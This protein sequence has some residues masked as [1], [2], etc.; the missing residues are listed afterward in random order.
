MHPHARYLLAWIAALLV[1]C[2][3]AALLNYLIDPY[4]LFG[5]PRHAG[6]NEIK[7]AAAERVRVAKPYMAMRAMPKVVIGGNSRPEMGLDP[8]SACWDELDKPV[9]NAAIP[10]ADVFMQVRY[11]QHAA[12]HGKAQQI[13]FGVDFLDFLIEPTE[14][15]GTVDWARIGQRFEGRLQTGSPSGLPASLMQ[16]EDML[17]GLFSMGTLVDSIMTLAAQRKP[18]AATRRE[19]GFNPAQDYL[20]IIRSEGQAVLFAQ[21]NAEVKR[22]LQPPTL[23]VQ[24]PAGGPS[25]PLMAL[26]EFLRWGAERDIEIVLFINPYHSDYL[27]QIAASGKWGALD[28]WKRQLALIAEMYSVPLWDF[29]GFD[30][31]STESP[32]AWG[33][34]QAVLAWYWE[35]AHY[36]RELGDQMLA[37]MLGRACGRMDAPMPFGT[38]IAG[39]DLQAHLDRLGADLGRF[40]A[41]NPAVWDRLGGGRP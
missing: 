34:R 14:T 8:R 19:D 27:V 35:P 17:G 16:A 33:D 3:G 28:A 10:G 31:Y 26:R 11:A 23:G 24:G 38:R 9:F 6:F 37:T 25:M 13:F 22:R 4:G 5:T 7:P 40:M 30:T 32:P 15:A 20:P 1:V 41:E 12:E 39:A 18:V 36:R 29:N 21:K 2:L